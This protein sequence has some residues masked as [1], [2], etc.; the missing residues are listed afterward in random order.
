MKGEHWQEVV[1]H[2]FSF[3]A[4]TA[5]YFKVTIK[6]LREMPEWHSGKGRG[7]YVFVDEIVLN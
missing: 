1:N 3:D 7:A 2:A 6:S 5:R 4:T